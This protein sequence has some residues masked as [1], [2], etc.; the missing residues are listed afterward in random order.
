MN[1]STF[2][3]RS[4]RTL[5]Q[6]TQL[7]F[8]IQSHKPSSLSQ[9]NS[10]L[11]NASAT[12]AK[13]YAGSSSVPPLKGLKGALSQIPTLNHPIGDEKFPTDNDNTG[14][15]TRTKAQKKADFTNYEKHLARRKE[16]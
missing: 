2:S 10:L 12:F 3:R 1:F 14:V 11:P 16:L 7:S 9:L 4:C 5:S 8:P 6:F 13:R 15:D